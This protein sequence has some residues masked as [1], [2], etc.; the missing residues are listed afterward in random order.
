MENKNKRNENKVILGDFHYCTINGMDSDGGNKTHII[1]RCCSNYALPKLVVD[2]GLADLWSGEN[3]D[4][5]EFVRYDRSSCTN[6]MMN[7]VYTDLKISSNTKINHI[8]VSLIDLYNTISIDRLP[9]K[10][11]IGK[12]FMVL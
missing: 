6:S 2:N 9:S 11:K 1:Y 8:M 3:P 7:N 10:T 4:S 12:K 5:S